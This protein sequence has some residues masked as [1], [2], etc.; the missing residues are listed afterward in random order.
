MDVLETCAECGEVV[1][2][3]MML[4]HFAKDH[5]REDAVDDDFM[6]GLVIEARTRPFRTYS[7]R[8]LMR[9]AGVGPLALAPIVRLVVAQTRRIDL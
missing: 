4:R 1:Y 3:G 8:S 2:A 9:A 5:A 6:S 7:H